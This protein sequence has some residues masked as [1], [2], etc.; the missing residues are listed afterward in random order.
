MKRV[1][2]NDVTEDFVR[3]IVGDV[4]RGIDLQIARDVAG[5]AKSG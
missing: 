1:G 4:E 3:A 5:D 2:K